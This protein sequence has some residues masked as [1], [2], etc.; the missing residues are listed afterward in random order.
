MTWRKSF[1]VEC[2]V[3]T[4]LYSL[5][6]TNYESFKVAKLS[7]DLNGA[8]GDSH[9]RMHTLSTIRE[10]AVVDKGSLVLNHR[11]LT[12]TSKEECAQIA[13]MLGVPDV[14]PEDM[15]SNIHFSGIEELTAIYPGSFINF[16]DIHDK[17]RQLV[18]FVT[19]VNEPCYIPRERIE[20]RHGEGTA[21]GFEKAAY[22][23]RGLVAMVYRPGFVKVGDRAVITLPKI[24]IIS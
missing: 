5:P 12:L 6:H 1:Q 21:T 11:Q 8:I 4:L 14:L 7:C 23:R 18:L 2:F 13:S 9:S 19:A 20:L 22:N 17:R 3:E 24:S 10:E 15:L 16:F